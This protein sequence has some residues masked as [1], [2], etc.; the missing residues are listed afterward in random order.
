GRVSQIINDGDINF[1]LEKVIEIAL[2]VDKFP[3]FQFIDKQ[4][5][6]KNEQRPFISVWKEASVEVEA[7]ETKVIPIDSTGIQFCNISSSS[8]EMDDIKVQHVG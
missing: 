4:V 8:F 2:K 6:L 7:S 5:Y 3:N 1:S